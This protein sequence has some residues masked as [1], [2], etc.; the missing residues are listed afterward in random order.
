[1]QQ[2]KQGVLWESFVGEFCGRVLCKCIVQVYCE[3]TSPPAPLQ[4]RGV[5]ECECFVG[6]YCGR[7]LWEGSV[8]VLY[9]TNLEI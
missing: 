1:M 5:T 4:M 7:V 2:L 6:V 8:D 9:P 3:I